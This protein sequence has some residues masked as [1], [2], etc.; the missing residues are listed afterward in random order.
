[1][2]TQ[3]QFHSLFIGPVSTNQL[4]VGFVRLKRTKHINLSV[5]CTLSQ[6]NFSS[7]LLSLSMVFPSPAML[8]NS[9]LEQ[10]TAFFSSNRSNAPLH[11]GRACRG[12]VAQIKQATKSFNLMNSRFAA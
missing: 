2:M 8:L 4:A 11:S 10:K 3:N 1:M 5:G 9:D 6:Q 12:Q 7:F